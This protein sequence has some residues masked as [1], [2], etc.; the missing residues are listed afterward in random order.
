MNKKELGVFGET[1]AVNYL[2]ADG[3]EI[4]ARN[5]KCRLGE[6]DIIGKK[7]NRIVF[8]EVK[9]RTSDELGLP[10]EAVDEKKIEHIRK[11]A[12]VYMMWEK[13]TNY[14]VG[15]DVVEVYCNHIENAF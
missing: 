2:E 6:V 9:T 4:V 12:A 3:Y 11:V 5:F 14:D 13:V 10:R 7:D 8:F 1:I 15:F